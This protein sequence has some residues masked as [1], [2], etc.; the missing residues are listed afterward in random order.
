MKAPLRCY[1]EVLYRGAIPRRFTHEP[2]NSDD[3]ITNFPGNIY[4]MKQFIEAVNVAVKRFIL[5]R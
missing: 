1:T 2:R 5:S 3:E 4:V